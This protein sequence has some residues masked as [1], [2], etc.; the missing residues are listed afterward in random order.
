MSQGWPPEGDFGTGGAPSTE[1]PVAWVTNPTVY[2]QP[3]QIGGVGSPDPRAGPNFMALAAPVRPPVGQGAPVAP[4]VNGGGSWIVTAQNYSAVAAPPVPRPRGPP[5]STFGQPVARGAQV[6]VVAVP[7]NMPVQVATAVPAPQSEP[8]TATVLKS[9]L[10]K[11]KQNKR[12][13]RPSSEPT[14]AP[15][16]KKPKQEP[17][18]P[19]EPST[20]PAVEPEYRPSSPSESSDSP[21]Y[22]EESDYEPE[23]RRS[24]RRRKRVVGYDAS[25]GKDETTSRRS[26]RGGGRSGRYRLRDGDTEQASYDPEKRIDVSDTLRLLALLWDKDEYIVFRRPVNEATDCAPNYYEIIR[27]PMDLTTLRA[28]VANGGVGTLGDLRAALG[29][30]ADN[31]RLYN[32]RRSLLWDVAA[33]FD[34]STEKLMKKAARRAS[35]SGGLRATLA[36]VTRQLRRHRDSAPFRWP[37][38]EAV[39]PGYADV[40]KSPMDIGTMERKAHEGEYTSVQAFAEDARLI[41]DNCVAFNGKQS[42]YSRLA[43]STW[44]RFLELVREAFPGIALESLLPRNA[45]KSASP[46]PESV[47]ENGVSPDAG[48]A[49]GEGSDKAEAEQTKAGTAKTDAK[50]IKTMTAEPK[51]S[52]Q[53]V[54]ALVMRFIIYFYS[55]IIFSASRADPNRAPF[56]ILSQRLAWLEGEWRWGYVLLFCETFGPEIFSAEYVFIPRQIEAE[57]TG[58]S[59]SDGGAAALA[60]NLLKGFRRAVGRRGRALDAFTWEA[61]LVRFIQTRAR[62]C[63]LGNGDEAELPL[64]TSNW[65]QIEPPEK[66]KVLAWLCDWCLGESEG[67]RAVAATVQRGTQGGP[68]PFGKDAEKNNYYCF[69]HEERL[70]R[71]RFIIF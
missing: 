28:S 67:V 23:L 60:M 27:S 33:Q 30:I 69:L 16:T 38:D 24:T 37:V 2:A 61:E 64:A 68:V 29:L 54:N 52:V 26:R 47:Q 36:G 55:R 35:V 11:K 8:I 43:H 18:P 44:R 66:L 40:I 41:V 62:E 1:Y 57:L 53:E 15:P 56:P 50:N 22:E 13:P 49:G 12:K 59:V 46:S 58:A 70:V 14:A 21:Q 48:A 25:G 63:G 19:P 4:N 7:N 9:P 10:N 45:P 71:P 34:K 42:E 31:C 5:P 32:G 51:M 20:E 39:A 6:R 65:N 3:A 17:A